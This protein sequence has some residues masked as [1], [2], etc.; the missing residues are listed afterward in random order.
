MAIFYYVVTDPPSG[1]W[2]SAQDTDYDEIVKSCGK[3]A[4]IYTLS[5]EPTG[6]VAHDAKIRY[7]GDLWLDIDNDS[8]K[9]GGISP[10]IEKSIEDTRKIQKYLLSSGID[11]ESCGLYISGGKGFHI[12]IP[13]KTM[14]VIANKNLPKVY[15]N[16]ASTIAYHTS[17]DSIDMALYNCGKGKLLRTENHKR[18]NNGCYKI[19]ITWEEL[20]GMDMPSYFMLAENPRPNIPLAPPT[21]NPAFVGLYNDATSDLLYSNL[22]E[23]RGFTSEDHLQGLGEEITSCSIKLSKND[24]VD[25]KKKGY[26]YNN[27]KQAM[28]KALVFFN[29]P[30]EV[31]NQ[32]IADFCKNTESDKHPTPALREAELRSALRCPSSKGFSCKSMEGEFTKSPCM[33]CPVNTSIREAYAAEFRIEVLGNSYHRLSSGKKGEVTCISNFIFEPLKMSYEVDEH[34]TKLEQAYSYR[35]LF[36][37]TSIPP[38]LCTISLQGFLSQSAFRRALLNHA[39]AEWIGTDN[40]VQYL[41]TRVTDNEFLKGI[42]KVITVK[43]QGVMRVVDS[44]RL[45]EP[46][47]EYCWVQKG[48]SWNAAGV[49]NTVEFRGPRLIGDTGEISS[50][51]LNLQGVSPVE[52]ELSSLAFKALTGIRGTTEVAICLGWVSACWFKP[53]L[54]LGEYQDIFPILH[55]YGDSGSGKTELT[56]TFSIL[57]GHDGIN[58]MTMNVNS[59]TPYS[60][61]ALACSTTTVPVIFD[62]VNKTK[63]KLS[64]FE[65]VREVAKSTGS[66]MAMTRGKIIGSG[67][68]GQVATEV[69]VCTSP[70]ALMGTTQIQENEIIQRSII[71]FLDKK[72][73]YMNPDTTFSDNNRIVS[74]HKKELIPYARMMMEKAVSITAEELLSYWVDT[75]WV[76]DII[77]DQRIAKSVRVID[78]GLKVMIKTFEEH[79]CSAE[80]IAIVQNLHDIGLKAYLADTSRNSYLF[81][82][83]RSETDLVIDRMFEMATIDDGHGGGNVLKEG[84]HYTVDMTM[85]HLKLNSI[86]V[87]F[88]RLAKEQGWLI[89][90]S[91]VK[92]LVQSLSGSDYYLGVGKASGVTTPSEW[93]AFSIEGLREKKVDPSRLHKR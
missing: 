52:T 55:L 22:V 15:R 83:G 39:Q 45:P 41:R 1:T 40:E 73:I 3:H 20:D 37:N 53:M 49:K 10:A 43:K 47:D 64:L 69:T 9:L 51:T 48:W 2:K 33:G 24:G 29:Y 61:K 17:V 13:L 92:G 42:E 88:I 74:R 31:E 87:S 19:A 71:L 50:A 80:T 76:L 72:D 70:M 25:T 34:G 32:L 84:I 38:E 26:G 6:D 35:I 14:G 66:K 18:A 63:M 82:D 67:E 62:E 93:H 57:A 11:L 21:L 85:V 59:C 7:K 44:S 27:I 89:E 56:K 12:R 65:A 23:Q 28:A 36:Q 54:Q 30:T 60:L 81:S 8:L 75:E 16:I 58:S 86:Y 91:S 78:L 4:G 5:A 77:P 79:G 90:F 68:S 46:I